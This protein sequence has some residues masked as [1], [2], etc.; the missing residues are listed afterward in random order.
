MVAF[1]LSMMAM[2]TRKSNTILSNIYYNPSNPEIYTGLQPLTKKA[3]EKGV[4]RSEAKKWLHS[5]DAYTKHY[6][7]SKNF[8]RNRVIVYAIDELWQADL[9]EMIP[10][11]K[12]N[13][14]YR[15]I[16]TVIDVLSKFAWTRPIKAK[17]G[18]EVANAFRSIFKEKRVPTAIMTDKGK[19]FLN[20]KVRQLMKSYKVRLFA[21]DSD[22][23]ASVCERFNRTL[24][25]RMW[26]YFTANKTHSYLK[27]LPKLVFAYN[28]SVH[29]SIK[30]APKEVNQ[31]TFKTAWNNLYDSTWPTL[32]PNLKKPKYSVGDYVRIFKHKGVFS[33]GYESNFTDEI[34][35]VHRC[36]PRIPY[37][38][39]LR[40]GNDEIIG[41]VFYEPELV[42]VT[43]K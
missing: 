19:E 41:G 42:L 43:S 31:K 10:L 20:S 38:Y 36:L 5:Q 13:D 12:H 11:S 25:T 37:V 40:D 30:M 26:K 22:L 35:Q 27:Q 32:K 39:K 21:S 28:N 7:A 18:D 1:Y 8:D 24:K 29:R 33:K 3:R 9:V 4:T 15:Y 14:G 34:F 23:K 2:K 16:L 17:S 6:P